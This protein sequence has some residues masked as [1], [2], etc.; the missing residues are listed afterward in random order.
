MEFINECLS[1]NL[2]PADIMNQFLTINAVFDAMEV[3][4]FFVK[5]TQVG[6]LRSNSAKNLLFEVFKFVHSFLHMLFIVLWV[7]AHIKSV[8]LF[9][10][11]IAEICTLSEEYFER[12]IKFFFPQKVPLTILVKELV[13]SIS[14]FVHVVL[15]FLESTEENELV[16]DF[17]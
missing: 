16:L 13:A 12:F 1:N 6:V 9:V 8:L 3:L 17:N 2:E 11:D 10:I 4:N 5:F 14:N 15:N 7:L